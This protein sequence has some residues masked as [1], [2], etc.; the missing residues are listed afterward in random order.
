MSVREPDPEPGHVEPG[1][2]EP[3]RVEPGRVFDPKPDR[4]F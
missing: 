4:E 3:G 1:H 2:V